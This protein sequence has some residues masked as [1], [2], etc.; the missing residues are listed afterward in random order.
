MIKSKEEMKSRGIESVL[1]ET[2]GAVMKVKYRAEWVID[3]EEVE[4]WHEA[5]V[6]NKTFDTFKEAADR[7][8][9][10]DFFMKLAQADI[11]RIAVENPVCIMSSRWRKPDQIVQPWMFGDEATKTTC[12]WL[13]GLDPLKPTDIVGKG[14]RVVFKSGKSHPKWYADA[15]SKAKNKAERQKIRSATFPGFAEAMADQWGGDA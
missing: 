5:T 6:G 14:E 3:V 1:F 10:V 4:D 12:L 7:E 2:E 15:L 9:A 11:P 13:K 8:F